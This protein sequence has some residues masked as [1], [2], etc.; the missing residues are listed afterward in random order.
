[1]ELRNKYFKGS[2]GSKEYTLIKNDSSQVKIFEGFIDFLSYLE[3]YPGVIN[4]SDY[5]ICN[6]TA[7]VD[8]IIPIIKKYSKIDLY[9]DNDE[10][11]CKAES[12]IMNNCIQA[13]PKNNLYTGFKDLNEKL[14]ANV[15]RRK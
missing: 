14:V 4:F 13:R 5:L 10:S 1:M 15:C 12:L 6:S 3:I 8:R 11:G 2:I 7:I 9:M